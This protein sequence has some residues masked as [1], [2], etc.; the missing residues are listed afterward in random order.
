MSSSTSWWTLRKACWI[1]GSRHDGLFQAA[2]AEPSC[3]CRG[4]RSVVR[5]ASGTGNAAFAIGGAECNQHRSAIPAAFTQGALL[6]TDHLGRDLLSRLLWGT[7]LS[8]AVG[9]AAAVLAAFF[10]SAIGI[11]AGYFGGR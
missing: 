7:R 9:V 3:A 2:R 10:G 8:L 4:D 5:R 1:R 11:T 6:G